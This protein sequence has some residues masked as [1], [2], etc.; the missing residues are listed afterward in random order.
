[1]RKAIDFL[2]AII[3]FAVLFGSCQKAPELTITSSPTVELNVDGSSGTI[4]FTANR[5]WTVSSSDSWV[6]ISPSS[7]EASDKPVTVTVRCNANTTYDDRTATVTIRMEDLSQSVTIKQPANKG[8]VLPKQVF[9][10][11]S[12]AKS[13][14]VEVQANVQ[15]TVSTSVDWIKQTGTKGLTPKTLTFS[16]E[17]N[18]TYDPRE[19][20]ITIKPQE[21]GA[22]EQVISVRQAQ[23]DALVVK[24]T[25]Y[26]MP[27]GGGE[28]EIKVEA[29]VDFDVKPSVGWV[30]YVETK[31]MSSSTVC[32]KVDKNETYDLRTGTVEIVQKNGSLSHTVTIKQ[33][34]ADG[35]VVNPKEFDLTNAAQSIEIEVQKNI[36][37][38]VIV[39]DACK[40]W[41]TRVS[42]KGLSSEKVTFSIAANT[43]YDDREGK[44]TFKQTNGELSEIVTV[45][46][47]QAY[48]LFITNP[49]Y[50]LSNE[51]H[52]LTVEVKA[53]VEY[54]VKPQVDWV[55]VVETKALSTTTFTLSVEANESY[56]NRNGTVL[57][58]QTN[59]NLSGTV[60]IS[61]KQT[62]GMFVSPTAFDITDEE[63]TIEIG[64]KNN[65]SFDIVIPE[66]AKEWVSV[67]SNTQTKALAED[68]VV[69]SIAQNKTYDD[70]ETSVT[71]KEKDG[72]LS[73]TVTIIQRQNNELSVTTSDYEVSCKSQTIDVEV[74]ANVEFE[75]T[76]DVDWIKHISTKALSSSTLSLSIEANNTY[77]DRTGK[78]SIKQKN[79]ELSKVVTI[80]QKQKTQVIANVESVGSTFAM[81]SGKL[82]LGSDYDSTPTYRVYCSSS[83][84]TQEE[85]LSTYAMYGAVVAEDGSFSFRVK[86]LDPET[87]YYF[88]VIAQF[89]N[90]GDYFYSEIASFK[91]LPFSYVAGE[92][93]DLGLSVK[94]SSNNLGA[95]SAEDSG[96]YFAW[97]ETEPKNEF[98]WGNYALCNGS[99]TTLLKYNNKEFYGVVDNLSTLQSED[100][101][102]SVKLG[103][104]WRMPTQGEWTE[105]VNNCYWQYSEQNGASGL[106]ITSEINGKSIFLPAAAQRYGTTID[107][108]NARCYY[109]TSSKA[110]EGKAWSL[111]ATSDSKSAYLSK[112][113]Y[114]GL[115]IRPVLPPVT[116]SLNKY[117]LSL[118]VGDSETLEATVKPDN[119]VNKSITWTSSDVSVA[120]VDQTGKVTAIKEGTATITVKT[121]DRETTCNVV[122]KKKVPAG[123]IDLGIEI[124]RDDGSTYELFWAE[125][126][127]G[128]SKPE[129]YGDYFAWGEIEP[130]TDYTWNTYKWCTGGNLSFGEGG[131]LTKY[132]NRE[133]LGVVDGK[134]QLDPE[135]DA[136]HVKLGEQWRMPTKDEF[137][138]F[139]SKC[140]SAEET[141]NGVKGRRFTSKTTGNSIFL[142]YAGWI[143]DTVN[144]V[145]GKQGD[146]WSSSIFVLNGEFGDNGSYLYMSVDY[147]YVSQLW[148]YN[149]F[150]IRPVTE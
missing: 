128:A 79:G 132:N 123:A 129:E 115:P 32:L 44:I 43:D 93:V 40:S 37:Y 94:W 107:S 143:A 125:C 38:S 85:L 25:N 26:D 103:N 29:N 66:A 17:E 127:L 65:V 101:A 1:M 149:G 14:D 146:Y 24:D 118:R 117:T 114:Y 131:K 3:G 50:E 138:A 13:I 62:N 45:R 119:A 60:T 75:V 58:K 77:N 92:A 140:T 97:G 111:Y 34:Q 80:T 96:A 16:I 90:Y 135:D 4:T 105:L 141:L 21:S 88:S 5:A 99:E 61:Q 113:R 8:V 142:P 46:Q 31:A 57:V 48:G 56:D 121:V 28:I 15:Y 91:T 86:W 109:W 20:K 89:G 18:K 76:P 53:N 49:E 73:E 83:A 130:K 98:T 104:G 63:Q 64:V 41:I 30:H 84:K 7:G 35:L 87:D 55:K 112:A 137:Q 81:L 144:S 134:Q 108:Q 19:G 69:L 6:T 11:Q 122:V 145:A 23:K 68:I 126:N 139:L 59:G 110:S 116:A 106:L 147:V 10:L 82:I 74:S 9:D 33:Q 136:A 71:I 148:R 70:R 47:G 67:K 54:E 150:P 39:D 51:A 95:A 72:S 27:S 120:T 36:D 78:V 102:A 42:T 100:D 2:L 124:K 52:T 133:G 22:Q 12:D